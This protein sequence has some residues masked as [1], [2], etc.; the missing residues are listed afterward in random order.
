MPADEAPRDRAT[1]ARRRGVAFAFM[2]TLLQGC[3]MLG[4]GELQNLPDW[5][6]HP[7]APKQVVY[8]F[9]EHRYI[10]NDPA[11]GF[12]SPCQG[13]LYYVDK[14]LGIR[15]YFSVNTQGNPGGRFK[16][17][18]PYVVVRSDKILKIS[19]DQGRTFAVLASVG[20]GGDTVV[21]N[22]RVYVL[23]SWL[24]YV[25][26]FEPLSKRVTPTPGLTYD[27]VQTVR[28]MSISPEAAKAIAT[29]KLM[30]PGPGSAEF[31]CRGDLP[32]R[33]SV[34]REREMQQP[35]GQR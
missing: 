8:R 20:Y 27:F 15:T 21:I 6:T 32:W 25:Y 7:R 2:A 16:V 17:D 31:I 10:E 12:V 33:P 4:H 1:P 35:G 22:T 34:K 23:N 11:G 13:E 9:D 24:W 18:S 3:A 19:F 29:A 5:D 28:N 14:T 26:D 30:E